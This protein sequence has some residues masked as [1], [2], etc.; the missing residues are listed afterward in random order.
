MTDVAGKNVL[1]TG[2]ASGIGRLMAQK[3]AR[4]GATVVLW[5]L[6]QARLD[7]VVAAIKRAGGK[8]HGYV[9]DVANK[10]TVAR[11]AEEVRREVGFVE[12]LVN[13][14]GV[15]SGDTLLDLSD[16]K[17]ETTFGVNALAL[18]W[19]TRAFLREMVAE[20]RG[21]VVT[22]ASAS[23]YIGVARLTDYAASK[24]AAVGFDESLRAELKDLAPGVRTTIV[25]PYY[26]DTGMF[27]GVKTRFAW[28]LP[29]LDQEK[30]AT[31]VVE[32]IARGEQRVVMPPM[33][34]LVPLLRLLPVPVFDGLAALF[35]IN[36]SMD[37]FKGRKK[38]QAKVRLVPG[39]A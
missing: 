38:G 24:W 31:R 20:N 28:L 5:D 7:E 33:V 17:I 8:A 37:E 26:I 18:F 29:I 25:C 34:H 11:V 14:A 36:R 2:G 32:A 30:V 4:A 19:V 21:H 27:D 9:C 39:G 6:D 23:G 12:V 15:V 13:N 1:I 35:G 3:L 22:I 10:K 16:K